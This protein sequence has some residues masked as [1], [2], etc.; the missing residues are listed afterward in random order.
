VQVVNQHVL[1]FAAELLDG[2]H[3]Q[4]VRERARR[5]QPFHA[6]VDASRF[7]EADHNGHAALA[8]HFVQHNVLVVV[9]IADYD[10][11][12]FHLNRH[13]CVGV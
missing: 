10:P 13:W 12:Q 1:H 6:A 9:H 8:A 3:D 5:F 11:P 7:E 4:I 2:G